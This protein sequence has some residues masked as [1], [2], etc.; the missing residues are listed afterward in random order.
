MP[1]MKFAGRDI[2]DLDL[3][4]LQEAEVWTLEQMQQ[5]RAW[6]AILA[7]GYVEIAEAMDRAE[8]TQH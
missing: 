6:Y 8:A 4:E 5:A 2:S 1:P 3:S 7:A